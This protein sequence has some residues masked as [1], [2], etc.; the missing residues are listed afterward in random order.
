[1]MGLW[2]ITGHKLDDATFIHWIPNFQLTL[3]ILQNP[4]SVKQPWRYRGRFGG[5]TMK[6]IFSQKK[7][8]S[9]LLNCFTVYGSESQITF[10]SKGLHP[11]FNVVTS[12]C[13]IEVMVDDLE[14][15]LCCV[16]FFCLK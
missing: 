11:Y 8:F 3:Y 4:T 14:P 15:D 7:F 10:K 6:M 9:K 1:M 2:F 13:N 12:C 16:T 5:V